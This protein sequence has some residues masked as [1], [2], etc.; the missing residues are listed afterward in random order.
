VDVRIDESRQDVP[1]RHRPVGVVDPE[2]SSVLNVYNR[3]L[4]LAVMEIYDMPAK[5]KRC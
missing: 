2:D 4:N 1:V 3:R 5:R